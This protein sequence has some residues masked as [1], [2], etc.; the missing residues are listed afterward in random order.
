[1]GVGHRDAVSPHSAQMGS[2]PVG[3]LQTSATAGVAFI[4]DFF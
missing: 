3:I 1:M 2:G 4:V